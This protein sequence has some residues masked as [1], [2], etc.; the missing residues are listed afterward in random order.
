MKHVLI[1]G[2][3]SGIGRALALRYAREGARLTLLGRDASRLDEAGASCRA[4]GAADVVGFRVDVQDRVAMARAVAEALALAPIDVLVANAGVATGLS[5]GQ[6]LENPESVRAT[7]SINVGGVLNTI[8]PALLP[9]TQR[10]A[11]VIAVVGSMAGVRGLPF[12][13]AYCASKAAAHSYAESLRGV[14]A[15]HGVAVSLIVP[16]YV[17]TPMSQRTIVKTPMPQRTESWQP[18]VID[19]PAAAEI[20]FRGLERKKPVIAFPLYMFY[21]LRLFS[22]LP[23]RLVDWAMT[24]FSADVPETAEREAV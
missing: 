12:S 18:G 19:A 10:G 5:G 13:P 1:T 22:L 6:I 8:E 7:L 20:I 2:A 11:G 9:M 15:R 4:Q 16:G 17:K 14:V 21:A 24:R 23:P 3:S